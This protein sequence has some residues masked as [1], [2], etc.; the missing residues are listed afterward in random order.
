[1]RVLLDE[2]LPH[3]LRNNLGAHD[4]FTVRYKGWA[5]LKNGE[6]L[7]TAEDDGFEVFLTGDQ[8]ISYEQNLTGRRLATVVLSS[9]DWRILKDN[10]QPIISALDNAK[11]GSFQ[12]VVC[13]S[14]SRKKQWMP[15][16]PWIVRPAVLHDARAIAE[17]H[18]ASWKS[19][20]RGIF[21]P[22]VL[23]GLSV[24]NRESTWQGL[25][26]KPAITIVGC[27]N[28][29]TI[30]GFASGGKERTGQSGCDGE[31][32][33]IYLR[34]EAQRKGL[35]SLLVREIVGELGARG[36][37]SMAVWVLD[38]NP[39]MRFYESLGGKLIGRQ[40]IERGGQTFIEVAYGWQS[41]N[42]F[43]SGLAGPPRHNA[44]FRRRTD[45]QFLKFAW[46]GRPRPR[47]TPWS[48]SAWHLETSAGDSSRDFGN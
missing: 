36:F 21:P 4:V 47:R 2:N 15:D 22:D 38:L 24:E 18:V 41:L 42:A 37:S 9:I 35:G 20:Y 19:T 8:T 28:T 27:D 16:G 33:A 13:G 32:Y 39:S 46:G 31:L 40:P 10:L 23:D 48:G 29:G 3:L 45:V 44:P 43:L 12:E 26:A 17:V 34:Q 11:P 30:A 1:M 5:G 14:F 7:K 6:L 25:L